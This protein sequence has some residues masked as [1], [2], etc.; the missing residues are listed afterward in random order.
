[1]VVYRAFSHWVSINIHR[2][3]SKEVSLDLLVWYDFLLNIA[4]GKSFKYITAKVANV[5]M[6]T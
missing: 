2:R 5:T 4:P 3:I 1:M 6:Y